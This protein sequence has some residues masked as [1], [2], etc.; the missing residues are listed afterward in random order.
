MV[1]PA[2]QWPRAKAQSK[3]VQK[4]CRKVG[5]PPVVFEQ[6]LAQ[7][8]KDLIGIRQEAEMQGSGSVAQI[9]PVSALEAELSRV[10]AELVQLKGVGQETHLPFGPSVKRVCRTGE[11]VPILPMPTLVPAELSAWLEERHSELHDALMQGDSTRVLE[12]STKLSEGAERMD[13]VCCGDIA[14]EHALLTFHQM[15]NHWSGMWSHDWSPP[16]WRRFMRVSQIG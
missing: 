4:S 3:P 11:R 12:L 2:A 1:H 15:R 13:H 6:E 14:G 8:E 5:H 10:R 16:L 9:D 7:A